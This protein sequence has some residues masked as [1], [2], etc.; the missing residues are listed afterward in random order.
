MIQNEYLSE[1]Y[2]GYNINWFYDDCPQNPRTEWNNLAHMICW[3]RNYSLGD[4]HAFPGLEY[5]LSSLVTEHVTHEKLREYLL[6]KKGSVWL[7]YIEHSSEEIEQYECNA[8]VALGYGDKY[9]GDYWECDGPHE[10]NKTIDEAVDQTPLEYLTPDDVAELLEDELVMLPVSIYD[11]SGVS[12]WLGSPTC[13]WDSG[14]VG[15]MYLTKEDAL[16][17]LRNCTEENWRERATQCMEAEMSVYDN[18]ISGNVYGF[19]IED[20]EG[21]EIDSCWGY[22][23]DDDAKSQ[24]IQNRLLI[25]NTILHQEKLNAIFDS[26]GC[27]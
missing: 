17:Q 3:H 22:Y 16:K 14:Q 5:F 7:E 11:H 26:F 23:G 6:S 18:Y 15:F 4:E 1:T 24:N 12:I 8:R 27:D 19:V 20:E 21:N 10:K 2:R 25:D 9:D 13:M